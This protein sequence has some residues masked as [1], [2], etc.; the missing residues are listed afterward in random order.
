MEKE[1]L[2]VDDEEL[3]TKSLLRL[4]SK[5]GYNT[6]VVK[7]GKEAIDDVKKSDFD[8]IICDV[9]MPEMDGIETIKEIRTHLKKTN[10][11]QIPEILITGYADK[12]KYEAALDLKIADYLYKPFDTTDFLK[13]V[14]R[15]IG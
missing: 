15:N 4:L 1:I 8:L 10:K 3:I 14:K 6:T 11:K 7:S 9:R 12:E 5:E 2:V 13:I